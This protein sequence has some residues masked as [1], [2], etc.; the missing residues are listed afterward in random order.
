MS[1]W[2]LNLLGWTLY[3]GAIGLILIGVYGMVARHDLLRVVISL[4]LLQAGVNLFI[5]A[6][7]FRP[8]AA[9]PIFAGAGA[10]PM[11]DPLPQALILTAIVIGVGVLALALALILRVHR[12]YGTVD[13]RELAERVAAEP[14]G[15]DLA[16]RPGGRPIETGERA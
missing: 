16:P 6:V 15:T 1:P 3:A 7:G 8:D 4:T 9:A 14:T 2:E 12:V 10:G 13:A 11:V 5:V